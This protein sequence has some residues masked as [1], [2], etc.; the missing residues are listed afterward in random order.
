MYFNKLYIILM[1][2]VIFLAGCSYAYRGSV[3]ETGIEAVMENKPWEKQESQEEQITAEIISA[4]DDIKSLDFTNEETEKFLLIKEELNDCQKNRIIEDSV[5]ST[6]L[7]EEFVELLKEAMLT[8]HI[9][10]YYLDDVLGEYEDKEHKAGE[11]QF[12]EFLGASVP[13]Y[14]DWT[15]VRCAYIADLDNDGRTEL[16]MSVSSGGSAGDGYVGILQDD[17][18]GIKVESFPIMRWYEALLNFNDTY[19]FVVRDYGYNTRET[20]GLYVFS[21]NNDGTVNRNEIILKNDISKNYWKETYCN[22]S[23]EP[24]LE[25]Q[26]KEYVSGIKSE[27]EEKTFIEYQSDYKLIYGYREKAYTDCDYDFALEAFS[28]RYNY[29]SEENCII[30]DFD[31]DGEEECI[32]KRIWYPSSINSELHL[33]TEFLKKYGSYVNKVNVSFTDNFINDNIW[34]YQ[35]FPVQ[36]WFEEFEGKIYT[37]YMK[38]FSCTSDYILE[39]SLIENDKLYPMLQYMSIAGKKLTFR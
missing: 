2:V 20:E 26:L 24:S 37:F 22:E 9:N 12:L 31:N 27:L 7:P 17:G 8:D 21:F 28:D 39:V 14:F 16:V 25:R 38:R 36:L 19:Y 29:I 1:A 10:G 5:Q 15:L 23:M 4:G 3:R 30:A 13:D 32:E 18:E 34:G 33:E 35:T 6:N 11:Q